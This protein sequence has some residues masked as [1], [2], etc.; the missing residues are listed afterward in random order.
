VLEKAIEN[1]FDQFIDPWLGVSLA[2]AK[3]ARRIEVTGD[4]MIVNMTL[5]YPHASR[6][7][8]LVEA[9]KRWLLPVAEGR[10]MKVVL[11][12]RI[13][14]HAG[15]LGLKALPQVKNIIAVASGKGGVGK[16]TV[17]VNTALALAKA[18]AKVG[19][20]DADIYGP[21]QPL[22][23]K[24]VGAKPQVKDNTFIPV[25][26]HGI[27]TMS[28]GYLIEAG[29]AMVWRGPMIGKAMQQLMHDTAWQDLDYLIVDLPPGT[30]DI[31]LTLCQKMPL[32]GVIMVTTPQEV[33]LSDVRRAC[34]MFTKLNVPILGVIENMSVMHCSHCGHAEHLFG[35]GGGTRLCE[36]EK[37]TLLGNIPLARSIGESTDSGVPPILQAPDSEYAKAFFEAACKAAAWLSLQ[38]EDFSAKF[39]KVV[40]APR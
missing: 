4:Q 33:A 18:G 13:R 16:S 27:Q 36:E 35:E 11:S 14:P 24:T 1:R 15:R 20:L 25:V 40:V 7:A 21:S 39:P 6:E 22:M 12:T 26:S 30:G 2:E 3:L 32:S 5:G 29:T 37:L 19:M 23:F 34:E 9:I 28:M 10:E 38:P 17:A 31:Q 8:D